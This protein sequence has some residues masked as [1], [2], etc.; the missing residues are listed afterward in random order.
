MNI[1]YT[2]TTLLYIVAFL[3]FTFHNLIIKKRGQAIIRQVPDETS[4]TYICTIQR[5]MIVLWR[6]SLISFP[7]GITR[8]QVSV[9]LT[10]HQI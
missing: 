9:E 4:H 7:L 10:K 1:Y 6:E 3:I 5:S 2:T 8:N